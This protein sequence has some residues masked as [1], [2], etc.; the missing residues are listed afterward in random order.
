MEIQKK[1]EKTPGK[2]AKGLHTGNVKKIKHTLTEKRAN[3]DQMP[4][5]NRK[6]YASGQET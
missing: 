1:Y 3:D 4:N 2:Q 5:S 6:K